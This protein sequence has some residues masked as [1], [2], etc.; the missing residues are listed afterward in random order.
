MMLNSFVTIN[1]IYC[2]LFLFGFSNLSNK[3]CE[4]CAQKK[5]SE[6]DSSAMIHELLNCFIDWKRKKKRSKKKISKRKTKR[7][8]RHH[9]LT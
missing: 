5:K 3:G 1:L 2:H 4:I 8:K 9:N 7:K 6:K